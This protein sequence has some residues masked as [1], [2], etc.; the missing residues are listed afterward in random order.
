[1]PE[2][3]QNL[4]EKR[5]ILN[6]RNRNI[7]ANRLTEQENDQQQFLLDMENQFN[8]ASTEEMVEVRQTGEE[9]NGA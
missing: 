1:M 8:D 6:Y 9:S 4:R 2:I 7:K 3:N 5:Q